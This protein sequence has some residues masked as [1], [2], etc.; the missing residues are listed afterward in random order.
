M[1][2]AAAKSRT[3]FRVE[4]TVVLNGTT[5]RWVIY[6]FEFYPRNLIRNTRL[7]FINEVYWSRVVIV[8]LRLRSLRRFTE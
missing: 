7:F 8:S 1:S 4:G 5:W 3:L 2:D 6:D